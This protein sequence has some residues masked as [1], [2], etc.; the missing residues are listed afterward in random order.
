M[1][2]RPTAGRSR[3]SANPGATD[4]GSVGGGAVQILVFMGVK[5]QRRMS[6]GAA[7]TDPL[8]VLELALGGESA[9]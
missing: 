4:A 3:A 7:A 5:G 8:S 6:H 2:V 9:R 1:P